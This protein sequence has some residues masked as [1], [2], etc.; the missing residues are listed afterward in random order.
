MVKLKFF[1]LVAIILVATPTVAFA[2]I[3]IPV[4]PRQPTTPLQQRRFQ[5]QQIESEAEAQ[6]EKLLTSE[7]Q[8]QY[9][10][11]R[12]QGA[13]VL[14]ALDQI[15][16]LSPDQKTKINTIVRTASQRILDLTRQQQSR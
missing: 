6:I 14:D 8:T 9:K 3:S 2:Q 5:V 13:G 11:A 1:P 15:E 4:P 10:Q 16:N 7:Q 12:R